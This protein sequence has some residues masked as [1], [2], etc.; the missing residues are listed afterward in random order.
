VFNAEEATSLETTLTLGDFHTKW[1]KWIVLA[2]E[3]DCHKDFLEPGIFVCM[4]QY[5]C[6][7]RDYYRKGLFLYGGVKKDCEKVSYECKI[8]ST[9]ECDVIV[10]GGKQFAV[11]MFE[12]AMAS[13]GETKDVFTKSLDHFA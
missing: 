12:Q 6:I 1:E 4:G 8:V 10:A 5:E 7:I 3:S 13:I 9:E 2:I 11:K